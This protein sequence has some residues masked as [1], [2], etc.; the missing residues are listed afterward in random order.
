MTDRYYILTENL[1]IKH[2]VWVRKDCS[3]HDL[4]LDSDIEM[5]LMSD[6]IIEVSQDDVVYVK[7]R[8]T[9][10][11]TDETL[12]WLVLNAKTLTEEIASQLKREFLL[13]K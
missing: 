3:R 13:R 9:N 10:T 1:D 2:R 5:I 12:T 7:N 11:V 4:L 6:E 8:T